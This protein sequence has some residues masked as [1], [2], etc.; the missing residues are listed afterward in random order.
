[1]CGIKSNFSNLLI[2]PSVQITVPAF[3]KIS[4]GAG[5]VGN[6][7]FTKI[8]MGDLNKLFIFYYQIYAFYFHKDKKAL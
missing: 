7:P 8:T 2:A 3:S 5:L 4:S 6:K 1:M